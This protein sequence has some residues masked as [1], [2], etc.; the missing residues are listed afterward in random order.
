MVHVFPYSKRTGTVA[1]QM[2]DQIPEEIK[3]RR[4]AL[5]SQV[6]AESRQ[7]ILADTVGTITDVLFETDSNGTSYGHTSNFIEVACSTE[8][9][10]QGTLQ[11]VEIIGYNDKHCIGKL[12]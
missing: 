11:T 3:H 12:L 4:V 1:A 5:L 8:N 9:P 7:R 6:A 10:L 2:Q